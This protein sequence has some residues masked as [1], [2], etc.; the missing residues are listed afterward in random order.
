MTSVPD[1]IR[2]PRYSLA[3]WARVRDKIRADLEAARLP[4]EEGPITDAR[5]AAAMIALCETALGV[6]PGLMVEEGAPYEAPPVEMRRGPI[7]PEKLLDAMTVAL[8]AA[9]RC[10]DLLREN[11]PDYYAKAQAEG[12]DD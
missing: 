10:D 7:T 5:I 2:V 9:Q 3:A 6:G 12:A 4:G 1:R 8:N 11:F